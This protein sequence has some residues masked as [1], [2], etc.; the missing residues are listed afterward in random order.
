MHRYVT[1]DK[2]SRSRAHSEPF[3]AQTLSFC[4]ALCIPPNLYTWVYAGYVDYVIKSSF[5]SS[6]SLCLSLCKTSSLRVLYAFVLVIRSLWTIS[7][8]TTNNMPLSESSTSSL[9]VSL[10]EA[11][12]SGHPLL[13][14]KPAAKTFVYVA[15]RQ[16]YRQTLPHFPCSRSAVH[17]I[18]S[19]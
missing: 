14:A 1:N 5:I 9:Q 12:G 3:K 15:Y 10:R 2:V 17:V 6:L 16:T 19:S 13:A 18:V 4:M 7:K 11:F 8:R